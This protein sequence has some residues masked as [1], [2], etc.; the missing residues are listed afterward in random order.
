MISMTK[1]WLCLP[2][3]ALLLSGCGGQGAESSRMHAVY[4]AKTGRLTQLT[5]DANG[6]G[7]LDTWTYMDGTRILRAEAD[8]DEDGRIDRWEYYRANGEL[9]KVGVSRLNDGTVDAWAFQDALGEVSRIEISTRR[10][11][12]VDRIEFLENGALAR[13]EE[14]TNRDGR[15]DKWET[16]YESA[17][18][19]LAFDTQHRGAPDRR[20]IYHADGK[21]DHVETDSN[22]DGMFDP[23]KPSVTPL[24]RRKE[25][26]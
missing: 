15:T 2:F 19:I 10:D 20:L 13:V 6:N 17:L 4:D 7:R 11:S 1:P 25:R 26:P 12:R 24:Q 3:S 5:Y 21:L 14:D 22:G 8:S 23:V 9:E 18:A 16:Y